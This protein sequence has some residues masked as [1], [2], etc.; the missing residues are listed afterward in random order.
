MFNST[1][2]Q[3][4]D[5]SSGLLQKPKAMET[6]YRPVQ[7]V[8]GHMP[9]SAASSCDLSWPETPEEDTAQWALTGPTPSITLSSSSSSSESVAWSQGTSSGGGGS[10]SSSSDMMAMD[11]PVVSLAELLHHFPDLSSFIFHPQFELFAR[12][13][14]GFQQNIARAKYPEQR[15]AVGM[16]LQL[17]ANQL[18]LCLQQLSTQEQQQQ[19]H[20]ETQTSHMVSAFIRLKH[21]IEVMQQVL[22]IVENG[23]IWLGQDPITTITPILRLVLKHR[24]TA[25]S[26]SPFLDT[27]YN[28]SDN[29][30]VH[31][32][33]PYTQTD[34]LLSPPPPPPPFFSTMDPNALI[35]LHDNNQLAFSQL[36]LTRG[37]DDDQCQKP[38]FAESSCPRSPS[39]YVHPAALIQWSSPEGKQG[40]AVDDHGTQASSSSSSSES[41]KTE[42]G[43]DDDDS[44]PE[45]EDEASSSDDEEEEEED[46]DDDDEYKEDGPA[47]RQQQPHQRP[48]RAT[49]GRRLPRKMGQTKR[50]RQHTR[51]TATSYDAETTHYLKS[52]FFSIYSKRDKL[53]KEQRRQVQ[54]RT[55][56]KPRNIT[57]WFSNHKRR[58]QTSLQVFKQTVRESKGRV[59]TYDDF[60][61]WRRKHGL[62]D[63]VM[64]DELMDYESSDDKQD[65]SNPSSSAASMFK[66]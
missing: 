19:R 11:P 34:A 36:R 59:K 58:F 61:E 18:C 66:E 17:Q 33:I 65:N 39:G 30:P 50:T 56:L 42:T 10:S 54:Q 9:D 29:I 22:Q 24:Q 31:G 13:W 44:D 48:P 35:Y 32:N 1:C 25:L 12:T 27:Y 4:H 49:A 21:R 41:S 20:L 64:E 57:Y 63:D 46:D 26:S 47:C 60:L 43:E 28:Q 7:L 53:T 40:A 2:C 3:P 16:S 23:R 14:Y 51:R 15:A 6:V 55:G 38:S 5:E 52:V 45:Y 37:N 62:P 8:T